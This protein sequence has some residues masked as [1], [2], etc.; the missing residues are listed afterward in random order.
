[1]RVL[2][3][4]NHGYIGTVM[5]PMLQAKGFDVTGLDS[6]LFEGCV[7]GDE[8]ITGGIPKISYTRKD[9]RDVELSDLQ[10]VD[11]IVHLCALSNDPLGNFNPD[12]TFEINYEGSVKLAKLAKKA[13]VQ[14]FV[15]S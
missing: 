4:G 3:T 1:M 7:F 9:I 6:D 8:S 12:I 5:V 2:V 11:A 10:G 13:G 14:R 15:F